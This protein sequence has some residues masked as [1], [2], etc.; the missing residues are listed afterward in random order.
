MQTAKRSAL[1]RAKWQVRRVL[2]LICTEAQY[3]ALYAWHWIMGPPRVLSYR[4]ETNERLLRAF[5]AKIGKDV[6]LLPPIT[7]NLVAHNFANLRIG[8]HCI[9]NGNTF[10][11]LSESITLEDGASI[12]PGVTLM[13]HN[14]FNRNEFLEARLSLMCGRKPVVVKAG[15]NVK[16][17]AIILHGVTIGEEAVVAGAAV[18]IKSVPPRHFV[19]GTPAVTRKVLG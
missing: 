3:G 4:Y 2:R 19:S 18:V 6:R 7:F 5:G 14:R 15:G 9:V 10:F 13:T 17:N 12:G 16:A 8:D 1:A 11:D